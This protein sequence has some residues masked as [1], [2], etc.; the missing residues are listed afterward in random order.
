M[1]SVSRE[2]EADMDLYARVLEQIRHRGEHI[3]VTLA[4]Q[5]TYPNAEFAALQMRQT[6]ELIP[7]LGLLTHRELIEDVAS[8]YKRKS[9][10]EA[11]KLVS[12]VNP[13]Y[14]P[15]PVRQI[16]TPEGPGRARHE[17]IEDGFVREDE[18]IREWGWLS[19]LLHARN[20]YVGEPELGPTWERLR[21]LHDRIVRL[22]NAHEIQLPPDARGMVFGLVLG[23][24][25]HAHATWFAQM[26]DPPPYD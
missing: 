24:D 9:P 13:D 12:Q 21:V 5:P 20:P 17:A 14:W 2:V 11:A 22:L 7:M 3:A 1:R 6:L 8:A 25:G 19:S 23:E 18:W 16:L 4:G 26:D 10:Q 15:V